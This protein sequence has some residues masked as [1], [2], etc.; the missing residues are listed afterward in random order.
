MVP[1]HSKIGQGMRIQNL[2]NW[3]G[4]NEAIPVYLEKQNF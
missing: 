3:Y 4:K 2:V 1:F